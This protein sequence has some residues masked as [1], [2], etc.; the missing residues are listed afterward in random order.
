MF[1]TAFIGPELDSLKIC[2]ATTVEDIG[3]P[4]F[5]FLKSQM[6]SIFI[7]NLVKVLPSLLAPFFKILY[8]SNQR[9]VD[10][11]PMLHEF[12]EVDTFIEN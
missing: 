8:K 12:L 4:C 6:T 5:P 10:D 7:I 9:R 3:D 1:I 11:N 2:V